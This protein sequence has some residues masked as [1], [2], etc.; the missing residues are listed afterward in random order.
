MH[1]KGDYLSINNTIFLQVGDEVQPCPLWAQAK[2]LLIETT[3]KR[4]KPDLY[5]HVME[6]L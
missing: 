2:E 4:Q 1:H 5:H 3:K 6:A